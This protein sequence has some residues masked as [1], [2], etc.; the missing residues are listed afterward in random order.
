MFVATDTAEPLLDPPGVWS[1]FHGFLVGEGS[2]HA[3]SVVTVLPSMIAPAFLSSA[4]DVASAV[5]ALAK[6]LHLTV[7]A[8]GVETLQQLTFLKSAGCAQ[9]Q[10]NLF[11]Y[12][13]D[14]DALI[15]FLI[16]QYEKPLIS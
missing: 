13:L 12:P 14:E 3:N 15:G 11:S 9:C 1:G 6:K 10:G 7:V 8:E 5:I 4:T 16:R 2:V